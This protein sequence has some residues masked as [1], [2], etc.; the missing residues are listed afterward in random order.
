MAPPEIGDATNRQEVHPITHLPTHPGRSPVPPQ[1]TTPPDTSSISNAFARATGAPAIPL[2]VTVSAGLTVIAFGVLFYQ[3]FVTLLSDWWH[4]PE[5]GHGL[6][7]VPVAIWLAWRSGLVADARPAMRSGAAIVAAAVVV[8]C[9]SGL[10]AELFTMRVSMVM[11]LIGVAVYFQGFSQLRRWWLPFLLIGLSIPLPEIVTQALALPLQFK[12]SQMGAALLSLRHVP[13]RL[14]GNIIRL[15]G[16]ELFVTEACSGLRSLTALL[17]TTILAGE[18]VL[19]TAVGRILLLS[20]AI[21]IAIA[22]NGVR[23]FLT[24]FLVFFVSPSFGTGFM[25][26]T[27]GWLLFLV[28]L[29]SLALAAWVGMWGERAVK[30]W[31]RSHA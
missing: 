22:V 14:S 23:V 31:R 10:A 7:L 8:R 9:A 2:P 28:S 11:A 3:P 29:A 17:S 20:A 24:G 4:L 25:H 12:A 21:P 27:E 5:A 15:P 26:A 19:E 30:S 16:H 6:L 13:V 18:L 1:T